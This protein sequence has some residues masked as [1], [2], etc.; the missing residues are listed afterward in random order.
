MNVAFVGC[1]K[2]GQKRIQAVLKTFPNITIKKIFD[3]NPV[4]LHRVAEQFQLDAASSLQNI[5]DDKSIHVAFVAVP[6]HIHADICVPLIQSGKHLLCEKPISHDLKS[7]KQIIFAAQKYNRFVKIGSNLRHFPI[8]RAL[9]KRVKSG[10]FGPIVDL[11]GTIGHNG[12]L[13]KGAWNEKRQLSGGGTL[14][15]NG[16]HLIDYFQALAGEFATRFE[17]IDHKIGPNEI[18]T[19]I[20]VRYFALDS[21]PV[22]I[23]SSWNK[24]DGYC[25][26]EIKTQKA[27]LRAEITGDK[28]FIEDSEKHITPVAIEESLFAIPHEIKTFFEKVHDGYCDQT[29]KQGLINLEKVQLVYECL[30]N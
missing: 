29:T 15:D 8:S 23:E 30:W 18:E 1:G 21:I 4:V 16:I 25:D 14:I 10:E 28:Y 17:L 19:H 20:K 7:A 11:K 3:S 22:T 24:S 9:F 12:D 5:L 26:I 13:V 6:N 27:I 2:F